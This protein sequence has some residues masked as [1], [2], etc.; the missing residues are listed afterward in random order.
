MPTTVAATVQ[1]YKS[2]ITSLDDREINPNIID[3]ENNYG[4]TDV[5]NAFGRYET[6]KV[7]KYESFLNQPLFK[8]GTVESV[9]GSPTDTGS[10]V[11]DEATSGGRRKN[12][13]IALANGQNARVTNVVTNSGK[14]TITFETVDGTTATIA[15]GDKIKFFGSVVGERSISRQSVFN[16][17]TYR[18]NLIQIFKDTHAVS[19][20]AK[21][22]KT[23]APQGGD[24]T[25]KEYGELWMRVKAQVNATFFLGQI[26]DA[27]ISTAS[28]TL[29]DPEGGGQSQTTRGLN[30]YVDSWGVKDTVATPGTW[31]LADGIDMVDKLI[32]AKSSNRYNIFGSS[33]A[34]GTMDVHLKNLGSSGVTSARM[35]MDGRQ[36]DFEVD[37][38]KL[39][40]Y[41]FQKYLMPILNQ[42]DLMGGT[43]PARSLWFMP[44]GTTKVTLSGEE[45]YT[46]QK[47]SIQIRY[48]ALSKV[49]SGSDVW[50][51]THTGAL[52]PVNPNGERHEAK[53]DITT[54]QG[55][56]VNG[57]EHFG[58]QIVLA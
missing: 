39:Q 53:L 55:L 8:Q 16:P 11:L 29:T 1:Q 35:N 56:E 58:R 38:F 42:P 36:L 3:I 51:E 19:D 22:S 7:Y 12:D 15:P 14:D 28:P 9:V 20:V 46:T 30:Q 18:Y 45:G 23:T 5:M 17:L 48:V 6:T 57:S 26:S 47:P 52:S 31:I 54:H 37:S 27:Q 13:Q 44:E 50:M 24:Y 32:A 2:L 4:L 10:F 49:Y 40:G 33:K 34:L 43:V 25:I 21:L 41:R